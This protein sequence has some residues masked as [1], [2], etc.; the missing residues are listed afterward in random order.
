MKH[1]EAV[2]AMQRLVLALNYQLEYLEYE[3]YEADVDCVFAMLHDSRDQTHPELEE[4][5]RAKAKAAQSG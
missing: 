5:A 1:Q 2:A 3:D 4:R